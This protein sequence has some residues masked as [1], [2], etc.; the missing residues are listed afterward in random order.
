LKA[1]R[2][3]TRVGRLV[4]V[5]SSSRTHSTRD[6]SEGVSEVSARSASL[7]PPKSAAAL[8]IGNEL[9]SGKVEEANVHVLARA[10]RAVGIELVRVVMVPDDI[11]VIAAEVR[12]LSAAH[13]WLFT[14]GGV[15]PTHD[16]VT[17]HAVAQ[18]F[19]VGVTQD[20]LLAQML[21]DH[22]QERCTDGHLQ[23]AM[24]PTGA[25]LESHD[26][27]RWPTIRYANT[28]LMPGVPEIFRMKLG[29]VVNKLGGGVSFVSRSVFT[30][31]DEGDLKA[32]LD[33][34]VARFPDIGIGSYPK[35]Q[36][37]TYKTKLTFDGRDSARVDAARDA[38]VALLPAGEPQRIE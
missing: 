9:L 23:M 20:P 1:E 18:A 34:V 22:Y 24:I 32:L 10:L 21:R 35:W 29:V 13:D 31:M 15:G 26:N 30:K 7:P 38:F 17:V 11:S 4:V 37:P 16:D 27:V 33:D 8:V 5:S 25:S 2:V 6:I 12:L 19:G 28:W 3:G 14:S 36:D